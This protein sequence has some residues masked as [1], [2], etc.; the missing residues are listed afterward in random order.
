MRSHLVVRLL[1]VVLVSA[2]A[3]VPARVAA[4]ATPE[5]VPE[6][7]Q[8]RLISEVPG[9][10]DDLGRVPLGRFDF[11]EDA[12]FP[13]GY[14]AGPAVVV[15]ES[16][17]FAVTVGSSAASAAA[18]ERIEVPDGA[19]VAARNT[20][21]AGSALLVHDPVAPWVWR[22]PTLDDIAPEGSPPT[23]VAFQLLMDLFRLDCV[24]CPVV[25]TV[26]RLTLPPGTTF[27]GVVTDLE[28]DD[29]EIEFVVIDLIVQSGAVD[30]SEDDEATR[31]AAGE[32]TEVP[33]HDAEDTQVTAVGGEPAVVLI[34]W[35]VDN[36]HAV[37]D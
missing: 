6:V 24:L 34:V 23:G 33:E 31:V 14:L 30:V 15:V 18:G 16:G 11:A 29:D 26:D 25:V 22:D 8:E 35:S 3:A 36:R 12:A 32:Y 19:V 13:P 4:T 9:T 17:T 1:P 37:D 21:E 10:F 20:G 5:P 27:V 2:L 28:T 7:V